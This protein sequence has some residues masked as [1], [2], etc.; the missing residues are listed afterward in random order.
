MKTRGPGT[1]DTGADLEGGP[2]GPDA[3][4]TPQ[5]GSGSKACRAGPA[6]PAVMR[7][8]ATRASLIRGAPQGWRRL[9]RPVRAIGTPSKRPAWHGTRPGERPSSGS[10]PERAT[11]APHGW[12]EPTPVASGRPASGQP[13]PT[14]AEAHSRAAVLGRSPRRGRPAWCRGARRP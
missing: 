9:R 3:E 4:G 6:L 2:P 10:A 8:S 5:P 1:E 14:E 11:T 13:A 12:E 7:T